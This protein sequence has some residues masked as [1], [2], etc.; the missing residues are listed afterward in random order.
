MNIRTQKFVSALDENV[1]TI[2]FS[3]ANYCRTR[4][5]TGHAPKKYF[6]GMHMH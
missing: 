1:K 2:V 4:H 6:N 3:S 5:M